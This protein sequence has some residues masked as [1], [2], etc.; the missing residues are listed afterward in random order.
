MWK[1]ILWSENENNIVG[2]YIYEKQDYRRKLIEIKI[3]EMQFG[4]I[5]DV[6]RLALRVSKCISGNHKWISMWQ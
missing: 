6:R 5:C 3:Q 4:F 2:Q 1:W